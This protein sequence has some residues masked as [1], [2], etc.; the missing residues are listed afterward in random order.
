MKAFFLLNLA[1]GFYNVGTIWAHQLDIFPSW[2]LAG[3]QFHEMQ[4][5][6]WKKLPFWVLGPVAVALAASVALFWYHPAGSPIWAIAGTFGCQAASAILTA[7]FWGPWQAALSRDPDG[8][9]SLSLTRIL[10][11]HWL[12]T[13]LINASAFILLTWA[14]V[15]L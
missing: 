1:L 2:R 7:F 12:R 13:A 4:A 11:T 8:A 14:I 5:K 3:A 6:H 10:Q 15:V 9:R